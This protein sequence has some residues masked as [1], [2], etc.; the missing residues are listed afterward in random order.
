LQ[1]NL[2]DDIKSKSKIAQAMKLFS[3]LKSPIEVA[4]ELDL[5]T[6]QVQ[7]SSILISCLTNTLLA[8][9]VFYG[10]ANRYLQELQVLVDCFIVLIT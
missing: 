7:T 9:V 4:I 5:A 2:D 10:I 1:A 6:D 3:E 8:D